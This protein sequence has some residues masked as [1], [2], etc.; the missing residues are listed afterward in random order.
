MLEITTPAS[1]RDLTTSEYVLRKWTGQKPD[2]DLVSDVISSASCF[3]ASW[4]RREF[5]NQGYTELIEAS[6][7]LKLVLSAKP[8]TEV[9]SVEINGSAIT[10][11]KVLGSTAMLMKTDGYPWTSPVRLGGLFGRTP[12]AF[13]RELSVEVVYT[14]GYV[15]RAM[16]VDEDDITL[17]FDLE[18]SVAYL[19]RETIKQDMGMSAGEAIEKRVGNF[20]AAYGNPDPMMASG[21]G[22]WAETIAD[23]SIVFLPNRVRRVWLLYRRFML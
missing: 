12:I 17:P 23:P 6:E 22:Y 1:T 7:R 2:P 10:D 5:V 21:A 16:T 20:Q 9:T 19:V 8:I 11:F 13:D 15:T 3:C 14:A 4:C 18:D